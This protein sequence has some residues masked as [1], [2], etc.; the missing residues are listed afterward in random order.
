MLYNILQFYVGVLAETEDSMKRKL[1]V[2]IIGLAI[3]LS[4]VYC[5]QKE[6]AVVEVSEEIEI[7][8]E[9]LIEDD[10]TEAEEKSD[11][12]QAPK[13]NNS[14]EIGGDWHEAD[15]S[16]PI[17][18]WGMDGYE[19]EGGWEDSDG[20]TTPDG[21]PAVER[22]GEPIYIDVVNTWRDEYFGHPDANPSA[23]V[24]EFVA[25][26]QKIENDTG[27]YMIYSNFVKDAHIIF[28][29]EHKGHLC[30]LVDG[31]AGFCIDESN[32]RIYSEEVLNPNGGANQK[33]AENRMN[34]LDD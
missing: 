3:V 19:P 1:I 18:E 34:Y 12:V 2:F 26:A 4:F 31:A 5:T 25:L 15:P 9:A 32:G 11:D 22:D 24:D 29:G 16:G 10:S 7:T 13:E 23:H 20:T 6:V 33:A 8:T 21:Y 14:E 30:F 17:T 27:N 28:T